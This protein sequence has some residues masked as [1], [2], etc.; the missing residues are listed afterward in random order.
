MLTVG[1]TRTTKNSNDVCSV[2]PGMYPN[3]LGFTSVLD[4]DQ[5]NMGEITCMAN[6]DREQ[7]SI[8][9]GGGFSNFYRMP[10]YQKKVVEK[11]LSV[12]G[13]AP[14]LARYPGYYNPINRAI[15]DVSALGHNYQVYQMGADGKSFVTA[16]GTSASTPVFA[17][18]ISLLNEIRFHKGLGSLGFVNP[19]IYHVAENHAGSFNDITVG[20]NNCAEGSVCCF[21][22]I[23]ADN[24]TFGRAIDVPYPNTKSNIL[25]FH[26]YKGWD[27][28]T[29]L[30]TPNY[31]E[32][33]RL[34]EERADAELDTIQKYKNSKK[35]TEQM[36]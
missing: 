25:G 32:L 14:N 16:D 4:C 5:Q 18:I 19:W 34:V 33:R 35:Q 30:G 22:E 36:L 29:G 9:S 3:G 11:Y 27:A 7:C 13:N 26:A 2:Y 12:S 21:D 31:P 15:P 17:G 1:G 24:K 8:T 28:T 23:S 10:D 6:G 20:K